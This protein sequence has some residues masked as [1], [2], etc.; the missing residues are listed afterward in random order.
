MD[1]YAK[2]Y[3]IFSRIKGLK[4][5]KNMLSSLRQF[6]KSEIAQQRMKIIK[7]YQQYGEEATKEAFGRR[8][9]G[10]QPLAAKAKRFWWRAG[11]PS[12]LLYSAP[13]NQTSSD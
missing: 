13:P 10:N 12:P 7:F 5:V 9:E 6:S 2:A 11:I 1:H 4:E 8:Q 3:P